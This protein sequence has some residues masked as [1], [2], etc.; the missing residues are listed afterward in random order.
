MPYSLSV[1]IFVFRCSLVPV[2]KRTWRRFL[3]AF[4]TS[5]TI[6]IG[7]YQYFALNIL[8]PWG[9]HNLILDVRHTEVDMS[10]DLERARKATAEDNAVS[11]GDMNNRTRMTSGE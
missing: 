6:D 10:H 7:F 8:N 3:A 5:R 1:S 9:L 4:S 2:L 11:N